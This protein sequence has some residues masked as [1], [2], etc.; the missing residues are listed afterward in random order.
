MQATRVC[1]PEYA[2][3]WE[4][5]RCRVHTLLQPVFLSE[6]LPYSNYN[7][8]LMAPTHESGAE[9]IDTKL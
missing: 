9:G 1:T 4:L 5:Q 6:G 2:D 3:P 8:V 7:H